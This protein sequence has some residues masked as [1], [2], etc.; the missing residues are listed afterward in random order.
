MKQLTKDQRVRVVAALCE[1]CSINSTVRLTGVSKPTIL[2]LIRLMGEACEKY[3]NEHVRGLTVEKVQCDEVWSFCHCKER[4]VPE[5]KRGTFGYG[6][7]WTWTALDAE[8]KLMISWFVGDRS[9]KSGTAFMQDVADRIINR[10]QLTTDG[11]KAYLDAVYSAFGSDVDHAVLQ[12]VYANAPGGSSRYSPPEVVGVTSEVHCGAPDPRH[13][14]TSF[15][16][17]SNLTVRMSMRRF[18][19]LTNAFS[20]KLANHEYAFALFA[21]HYNFCRKHMTLN[22]SP[23]VASGLADHVWTIEELVR[24]LDVSTSV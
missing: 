7:V 14:S 23:A 9:G 19:R 6:D 11:L 21:M 3:H 10:V 22:T 18:T 24:L 20:K 17:R 4:N 15:V 8:K 13:V 12:K 5:E 2:R 1:G 16:E